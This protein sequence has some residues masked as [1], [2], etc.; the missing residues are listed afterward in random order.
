LISVRP[1]FPRGACF[2]LPSP[3]P[4]QTMKF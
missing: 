1:A 4:A 2:F 3:A